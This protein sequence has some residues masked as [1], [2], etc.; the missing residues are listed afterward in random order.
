ML[1]EKASISMLSIQTIESSEPRPKALAP[2][3]RHDRQRSFGRG[4]LDEAL[5]TL[6]DGQTRRKRST[7]S[8][9]RVH[10]NK[11]FVDG[12]TESHAATP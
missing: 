11:V 1:P 5:R 9:V 8:S 2:P 7:P 3:S 10:V 12:R 4:D 6:K